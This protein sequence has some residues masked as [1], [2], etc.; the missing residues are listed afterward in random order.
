MIEWKPAPGY[1]GY[2]V[3]SVGT[4]KGLAGVSLQGREMPER[5][6]TLTNHPKGYKMVS[7]QLA[8]RSKKVLVHRLVCEAF[9]GTAPDPSMTD[10]CHKDEIKDN[11]VPENLEWGTRARNIQQYADSGRYR[12]QNTDLTHCKNNHPF[13]S[14]NTRFWISKSGS[15]HRICKKCQAMR[16]R[17]ARANARRESRSR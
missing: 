15:A 12:N 17:K 5:I 10:V 6:L 14:E 2:E 8:G 1:P 7:L 13:D 3:S 16:A 9:H 11:N 4:V